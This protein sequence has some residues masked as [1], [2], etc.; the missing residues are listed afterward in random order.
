MCGELRSAIP[1]SLL[2]ERMMDVQGEVEGKEAI[3]ILMERKP[4]R[5]KLM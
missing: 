5:Q 4:V 1:N 3:K 2:G